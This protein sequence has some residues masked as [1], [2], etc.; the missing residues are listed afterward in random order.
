[1]IKQFIGLRVWQ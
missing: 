1:M